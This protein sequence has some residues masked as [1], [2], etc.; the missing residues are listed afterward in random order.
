MKK[1]LLLALALVFY[2]S[3]GDDYFETDEFT[4]FGI[5][6][7]R[8]LAEYEAVAA[9][10]TAGLPDFS[11]VVY[12]EYSLNGSDNAEFSATGTLINPSWVLTAGHNFY[13]A[14]EQNSPASP[15]GILVLTGNDPNNPTATYEVERLVFHPTWLTDNRDFVF[16]N[17]LCLVKLKNPVSNI[18]P[19]SIYSA[20]NEALNSE[21]WFCGFGDYS[22][23]PDQDPGQLSKKH[24]IQNILDRRNDGIVSTNGSME[25]TGGL[26]AFDFD[27]PSGFTNALGD[28]TINEDESLLGS[29][30]S[31]AEP[32][33]LEGTT[34]QGD[35]G[36]P[37]FVKEGS[38]WKLAGVLSG[39][40]SE[41][42]PGHQDGDYGDISVFIRV[43]VLKDWIQSVIQ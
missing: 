40:A 13:V 27:S 24:A 8:S 10:T 14:E 2:S 7:D 21:V 34:V 12:F 6:H 38:Q 17:D 42:F 5:R 26:L 16:A 30:A 31:Q 11:P 41:V 25:Y 43:S 19:S 1:I 28:E 20:R 36:G 39:G 35:S 18:I 9:S 4:A 22:Q 15:N 32:L 37:L 3:C 23:Q 29:G 33:N